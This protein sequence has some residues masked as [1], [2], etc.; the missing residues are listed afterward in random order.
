MCPLQVKMCYDTC[1][2]AIIPNAPYLRPVSL[3][4]DM[5]ITMMSLSLNSMAGIL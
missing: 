5:N 3:E 4:D 1:F 2:F